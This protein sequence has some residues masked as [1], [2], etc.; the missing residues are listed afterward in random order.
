[1]ANLVGYG[2]VSSDGQRDNTSLAVQKEAISKYCRDHGHELIAYYEDVESA[3]TINERENFLWAMKT[4]DA[5][6][7]GLIVN[8]LDRLTRCVEDGEKLKRHFNEIGKMLISVQDSLDIKSEDGGFMFTINSAIAELERK[9]IKARCE[10]G[11]EKKRKSGGYVGGGPPYGF[12]SYRAQLIEVPHEQEVIHKV[13]SLRIEGYSYREIADILNAEG[14]ETKRRSSRGWNPQFVQRL[15]ER[16]PNVVLR[17][18][19][20]DQI[21]PASYWESIYGGKSREFRPP[22]AEVRADG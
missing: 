5:A 14:I 10:S 9:K 21:L 4:L 19:E 6:A 2:R 22:H 1:M 20:A 18:A 13:K 15:V 3:A 17:L 8:K 7:D 12:S 11:R 16:D